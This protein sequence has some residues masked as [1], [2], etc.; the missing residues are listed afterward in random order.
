M[1]RN[2]EFSEIESA[3]SKIRDLVAAKAEAE[4]QIADCLREQDSAKRMLDSLRANPPSDTGYL[5]AANK[6]WRLSIKAYKL[7]IVCLLYTSPSPRDRQKSRMPS[8]A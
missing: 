8:S 3:A 5:K 4:V 2:Y 1:S 6:A 7:S